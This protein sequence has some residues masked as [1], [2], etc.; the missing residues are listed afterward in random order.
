MQCPGFS[1][2][3]GMG[4][5]AVRAHMVD[6]VG[7]NPG[8]GKRVAHAGSH[9]FAGLQRGD[10]VMS[11]VGS[12]ET[13]HFGIDL[14]TAGLR[15]LKGLEHEHAR[16][17]AHDE[18]AA[19][20]VEG[21][22]GLFRL[23]LMGRAESLH[24]RESGNAHFRDGGLGAAR[25]DGIGTTEHELIIGAAYGVQSRGT[26]ARGHDV[27]ALRSREY[28]HLAGGHVGNEHG[29]V[30]GRN[31]VGA[32]GAQLFVEVLNGLEAAETDAENHAHSSGV[33]LVYLEAGIGHELHAGAHG[34]LTETVHL[35]A[36]L[37]RNERLGLEVLHFARDVR[38]KFGGIKLSDAADAGL[39]CKKG[40]P[41]AL[42]VG[43]QRSDGRKAGDDYALTIHAEQ[44]H[45]KVTG[46]GSLR[47]TPASCRKT[48][49]TDRPETS[50]AWPENERP[51]RGPLLPRNK[52][53]GTAP[54]PENRGPEKRRPLRAAIPACRN[55][56]PQQESAFR[57]R[58]RRS[59][60]AL[61][62]NTPGNPKLPGIFVKTR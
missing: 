9:A 52:L 51:S 49:R 27:D 59:E 5:R 16:A 37:G 10:H 56:V 25:D 40:L 12:A 20:G 21:T 61:N 43:T 50:M 15:V 19:S 24:G 36:L 57:F 14:R 33:A 48:P 62:P 2:V 38:G 1:R 30:E 35:A 54:G 45:I 44:L 22:G 7:R 18:A 39:A 13:G 29:N 47:K 28:G 17:F 4:G 55:I 23:V 58:G 34:Q 60:A 53:Q 42:K 3:V 8:I 32:G 46:Q 26:G 6:D 11:I 41:A 31:P